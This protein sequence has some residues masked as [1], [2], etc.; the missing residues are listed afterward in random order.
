MCL[1]KGMELFI[2][3][4]KETNYA[5]MLQSSNEISVSFK[6]DKSSAGFICSKEG[7]QVAEIESPV[8]FIYGD[9]TY[10]EKVIDGE[11]PLQKAIFLQQVKYSGNFRTL[12]VIESILYLSKL[13]VS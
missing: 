3:R 8:L 1:K 7:V 13:K 4:Y 10:L 11:M 9:E 5:N 12:L 6:G 2:K